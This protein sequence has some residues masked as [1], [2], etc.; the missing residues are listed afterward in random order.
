MSNPIPTETA[1]RSYTL[2]ELMEMREDLRTHPNRKRPFTVAEINAESDR[3]RDL[4]RS[5]GDHYA[6]ARYP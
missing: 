1:I 6:E 4:Y 5:M 3:R 2:N